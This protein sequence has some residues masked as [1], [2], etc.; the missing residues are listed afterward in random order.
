MGLAVR[1]EW[2]RGAAF[3]GLSCAFVALLLLVHARIAKRLMEGAALGVGAERIRRGRLRW[4]LPG[5]PA[6]WTLFRKDWAYLWRSPIPRRLVFSSVIAV[7]ALLLP[8]RDLNSDDVSPVVRRALPLVSFAFVSML[9][10]MGINIAMAANYFGTFDREGFATLVAS[11]VDRRYT[12]LSANLATLLYALAQDSVVLIVIAALTR[13]WRILPLALFLGVCLQIGHLPPCNLASILAPY[14]T[15]L[16]F[17]SG[18]R[19]GNL[20]GMVAWFVS[21]PP[22]LLL[23]IAPYLFWRRGLVLTLPLAALYTGTLY[24]LTLGPLARLLRR[25]EHRILEAVVAQ[26]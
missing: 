11:P 1:G 17:T 13:S 25:R 4:R 18:R 15:Q 24:V 9:I 20:W 21:A 22:V 5:P 26:E 14:R 8:L 2:G 16:K 10:G 7:V 3:L 23:I 19:H 6:F 12:L